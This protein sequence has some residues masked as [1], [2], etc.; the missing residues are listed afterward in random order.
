MDIVILLNK[1]DWYICLIS[2]IIE[3]FIQLNIYDSE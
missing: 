3:L 2:L 1:C